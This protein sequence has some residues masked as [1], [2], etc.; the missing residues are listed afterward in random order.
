MDFVVRGPLEGRASAAA[1][2]RRPRQGQI[3]DNSSAL[4]V[5]FGSEAKPFVSKAA[6][7]MMVEE[8]RTGVTTGPAGRTPCSIPGAPQNS[9]WAY[10][11]PGD[12]HAEALIKVKRTSSLPGE[13]R[14]TK[15]PLRFAWTW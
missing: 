12:A 11:C 8:R 9:G 7:I 2:R 15:L 13:L 5:S 1:D 6:K 4:G 14:M 3:I 10:T